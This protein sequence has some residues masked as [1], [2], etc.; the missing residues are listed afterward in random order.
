MGNDEKSKEENLDKREK[1][2]AEPMDENDR[3]IKT[4]SAYL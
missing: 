2:Y 3:R 1:N 4:T